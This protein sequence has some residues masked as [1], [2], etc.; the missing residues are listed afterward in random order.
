MQIQ[1]FEKTFRL[2]GEKEQVVQFTF[3]T[4]G[5]LHI[6]FPEIGQQMEAHRNQL[7]I[8]NHTIIYTG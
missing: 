8:Q 7:L 5:A 1:V 6:W 2:A 3:T 4:S